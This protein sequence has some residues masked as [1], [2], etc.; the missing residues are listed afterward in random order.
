M[1]R[2]GPTQNLFSQNALILDEESLLKMLQYLPTHLRN[3]R[4][5]LEYRIGLYT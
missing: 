2:P 1:K 4:L 5:R 3:P